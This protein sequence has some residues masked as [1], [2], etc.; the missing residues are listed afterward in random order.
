MMNHNRGQTLEEVEG[1]R[2][3]KPSQIPLCEQQR[4]MCHHGSHFASTLVRN[5]TFAELHP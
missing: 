4:V 1:S 3:L 2:V 5:A